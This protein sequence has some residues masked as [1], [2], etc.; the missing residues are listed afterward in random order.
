M[1]MMYPLLYLHGE[2]SWAYSTRRAARDRN[3]V[4]QVDSDYPQLSTLR[5]YYAFRLM[6]REEEWNIL[7]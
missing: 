6:I 5:R 1:I 4:M 3:A 7:Q 2:E